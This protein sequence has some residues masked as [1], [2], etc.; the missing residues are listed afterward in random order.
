MAPAVTTS[1]VRMNFSGLRCGRLLRLAVFARLKS[2]VAARILAGTGPHS[3]QN[4]WLTQV[5]AFYQKVLIF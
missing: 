5:T 1:L 4:H 2:E 3:R